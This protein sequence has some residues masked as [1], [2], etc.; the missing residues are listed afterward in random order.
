MYKRK[1]NKYKRLY[2]DLKRNNPAKG[3]ANIVGYF[4]MDG[5]KYL[6]LKTEEGKYVSFYKESI[7]NID[8]ND[9]TRNLHKPQK[10]KILV[11]DSLY[12][13]DYFTN[14]YGSKTQAS[15]EG[16]Q[17]EE[18]QIYINWEK[19]AKDYKG[20]YLD[21]KDELKMLRYGNALFKRNR[22]KSWWYYEYPYH[23]VLIFS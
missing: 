18:P 12:L 15:F 19:V 21:G 1:Y 14:K 6:S 8:D 5:Q 11:I 23:E 4:E 17:Y 22:F 7:T 16:G 9:K 3:G 2:L 10:D 13:F 20:F